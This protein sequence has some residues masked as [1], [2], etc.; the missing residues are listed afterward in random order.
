VPTIAATVSP[1]TLPVLKQ[2]LCDLRKCLPAPFPSARIGSFHRFFERLFALR[3]TKAACACFP[4][5]PSRETRAGESERGDRGCRESGPLIRIRAPALHRNERDST[6]NDLLRNVASGSS[7][8][9]GYCGARGRARVIVCA[10]TDTFG[11]C[12]AC[13]RTR[14]NPPHSRNPRDIRQRFPTG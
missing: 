7:T 1:S 9:R 6:Q 14:A 3:H 12:R 13:V 10:G 11:A 5:Q 4:A 8:C 2:R